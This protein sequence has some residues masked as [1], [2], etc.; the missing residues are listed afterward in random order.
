MGANLPA[1]WLGPDT[2][3][4]RYDLLGHGR[5]PPLARGVEVQDL[6]AQLEA[7]LC[8][9]ELE[10]VAVVGFSL[11]ALVARAYA[12]RYPAR[13]TQLVLL[14]SVYGRSKQQRDAVLKRYREAR[15]HGLSAL[16]DA[17]LERWFSDEFAQRRPAVLEQVRERLN[18]NQPQGFL[19]A[20]RLFAEVEDESAEQLG[21]IDV[22][23]WVITGA[24]DTGSTPAMSAR[25]AQCIPHA[26]LQVLDER[27]AYVAGSS[28]LN[29]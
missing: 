7:L 6:T 9:L 28:A 5:T 15:A 13:L 10:A 14:N 27:E 1:V 25:L 24:D 20:Y 11:G 29:G 12:L 22:P 19:P 17:A 8:D 26:R 16:V 18:N 21:A 3:V 23:T 2:G 4:L